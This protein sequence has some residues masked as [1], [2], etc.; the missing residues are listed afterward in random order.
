MFLFL[1]IACSAQ[2]SLI[3]HAASSLQRILPELIENRKDV[4]ANTAPT[5]RIARSLSMG[6]PGDIFLSANLQW[7]SY[8]ISE[9]D[10]DTRAVPFAANPLVLISSHADYAWPPE[11]GDRIAI[12]PPQVPVGDYARIALGRGYETMTDQFILAESATKISQWVRIGEADA[13][14][15]YQSEAVGRTDLHIVHRFSGI[16]AAYYALPLNDRAETGE[17]LQ[18]ITSQNTAEHLDKMGFE[19]P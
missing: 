11:A 3:I 1:S 8:V 5:S 9:L 2:P 4:Q 13:G 7:S 6:A 14:I 18:R 19:R 17:M 16:T 10:L 15:T 12:A